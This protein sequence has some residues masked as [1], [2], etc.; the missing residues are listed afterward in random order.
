M[1]TE[2]ED[3][4][5]DIDSFYEEHIGL[6]DF[7]VIPEHDL[8]SHVPIPYFKS[9]KLNTR[10]AISKTKRDCIR[11][12]TGLIDKKVKKKYFV[13][14][15]RDSLTDGE[16]VQVALAPFRSSETSGFGYSY[17]AV[18]GLGVHESAHILYSEMHN[19][20]PHLKSVADRFGNSK[21]GIYK[22][23]L[24]IIEDVRIE[25][26]IKEH[27][28]RHF[29]HLMFCS[30][31]YANIDR[32]SAPKYNSKLDELITILYD[33]LRPHKNQD[34]A[35]MA[36]NMSFL[37]FVKD[38]MSSPIDTVKDAQDLAMT[39]FLKLENHI[40]EDLSPE[41][42][43]RLVEGVKEM[44]S[45]YQPMEMDD[46]DPEIG[47]TPKGEA[48]ETSDSGGGED[49]DKEEESEKGEDYKKHPHDSENSE[50]DYE[51]LYN[52]P[53]DNY[54]EYHNTRNSISSV[55]NRLKYVFNKFR[56]VRAYDLSSQN[57]GK[58]DLSNPVKVISGSP[59]V[60]KKR[61][62]QESKKLSVVLLIDESGSMHGSRIKNAKAAAI[63]LNEAFK[64]IP[65]IDHYIY[66]HTSDLTAPTE[67]SK[68]PLNISVYCEGNQTK[69]PYSLGNVRAKYNNRDGDAI[70]EVHKIAKRKIGDN[71]LYIIIS[72]G[73]PQSSGYSGE[74]A[75]AHTRKCVK[76]IENSGTEI[77]QIAIDNSVSSEKMFSNY[78]KFT[79]LEELPNM[80][81][82]YVA[83]KMNR[84]IS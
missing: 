82:K 48:P 58:L 2:L 64:D 56:K 54:V 31:Y 49:P 67:P 50:G 20:G 47:G 41:D 65:A 29:R 61:H 11:M 3:I 62:N 35:N 27:K 46:E 34:L 25:Q 17:S 39:I 84:L 70:K 32:E 30:H 38:T 43:I 23:V 53:Q 68:Y 12:C 66:G 6:V 45:K 14:H 40:P 7:S 60:Y 72:D 28:P 22:T 83:K 55:V 15:D 63:A 21:T 77:I 78:I 57:S 1:L 5:S 24:N 10:L 80:L 75:V 36:Y 13:F 51:L 37:E 44:V 33:V 8:P 18:L 52:E 71:F 26:K 42:L 16:K 59:N 4:K 19:L 79:D 69:N 73:D 81:G 76:E 74:E 9:E